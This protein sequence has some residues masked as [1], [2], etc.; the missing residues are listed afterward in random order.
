MLTFI[1]RTRVAAADDQGSG[2]VD[3]LTVFFNQST[4][5]VN[6]GYGPAQLVLVLSNQSSED[7]T[8]QVKNNDGGTA[9]SKKHT[10]QCSSPES[11]ICTTRMDITTDMCP[12]FGN[13]CFRH[14]FQN[15]L[16]WIFVIYKNR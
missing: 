7:I 10:L 4:Y 2:N 6:E 8:V 3:D 16:Y 9:E 14:I 13:C 11:V 5:S 1:L 15:L 12:Y